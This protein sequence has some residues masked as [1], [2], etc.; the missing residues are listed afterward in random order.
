MPADSKIVQ[1]Q[2]EELRQ[3]QLARGDHDVVSYYPPE[4][5]AEKD[6][7]GIALTDVDG[8]TFRSGDADFPFPLQS[9]SK[10]F[11]YALAL[12]DHGREG[13]LRRVGVEPVNEPFHTFSFDEERN[14]PFNPMINAGAIVTVDML[15][16]ERDEK[17]ERVVE[18]LRI[19]AANPDLCVDQGVLKDELD[20]SDRNRGLSYL[21]RSLGMLHGDVDDN[22]HAYLALCSVH[23]T[24]QDLAT[25]GATL[26]YGGLNPITGDRALPQQHV[27]DVMT[28]MAMCGMYDA[29]GAWAYDVGIPAKSGVSGG[30]LAVVPNNVGAGFFS[31]GLDEFGNSVR[32]IE[33][34]RALS[35][36]FGLHVFADPD[37]AVLGRDMPAEAR[38]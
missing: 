12:E 30:I 36:R 19:Y 13:V 25:M 23:V 26:A 33:V 6:R 20:G 22:L 21:M 24:A 35:E 15:R 38:S 29:A 14:R 37:E 34:C 8:H 10:V 32:G 2:I 17:V 31:P 7:F 5:E 27:R 1:Q 18:R 11:S 3:E 4:L 9:V 28:V 16:G